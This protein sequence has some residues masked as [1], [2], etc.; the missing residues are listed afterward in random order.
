MSTLASF[1]VF[2]QEAAH[3]AAEHEEADKTLFYI[4]GGIAAAYGFLI[5]ILG[6]VKEDFPG[7]K[8]A[9]RGV[10][11]LSALVVLAAM[12]SSVATG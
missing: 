11:A 3:G 8:G 12:A 6:V 10:F 9:A 4:A 1:L 2:A 7:S 5:G